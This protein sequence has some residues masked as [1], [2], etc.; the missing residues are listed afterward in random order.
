MD[1]LADGSVSSPGWVAEIAPNTV[2]HTNTYDD[3]PETG[4]TGEL[5]SLGTGGR[6]RSLGYQGDCTIFKDYRR[7]HRTKHPL[8]IEQRFKVAKGEQA[9][10]DLAT[11]KTPFGTIDALLVVLSWSRVLWVRFGFHQE[12]LT[13]LSGLYQAFRDFG[14]VP[15]TAPRPLCGFGS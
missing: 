13:V 7:S 15:K 8:T 5:R 9:Q 2:N 10:V 1:N 3:F 4:R 11:F 14:G 6:G 12:Q